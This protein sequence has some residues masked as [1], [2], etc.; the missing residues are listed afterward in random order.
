MLLLVGSANRDETVFP[1]PDRYDLDRDTSRLVSFGSG[2]HFCMGAPMARMEARIGPRRTGQAGRHLRHRPRRDRAGPLDQ[3]A[4]PGR[5]PDHGGPPLM[6]RFE[7]N[8]E[9]RPGGGHRSLVGHREGDGQGAGRHSATRWPSGPDGWPSARRPRRRSGPTVAKRWPSTSTWPT[10]T[11]WSS[12]PRRP[13]TPSEGRDPG[14]QRGPEHGRLGARHRSR[15]V[16]GGAPGQRQRHP[17]AGPRHGAGHGGP[18]R[19]G[20]IVFVT[21]DVVERPR[22]AM[23]AYVTSKWGLE[24]YVRSLQMELEG[25]GVRATIVRPGPTLT[26]MGMDWDPAVTAEV[27]EQWADV[28]IRPPLQLHA[29]GRGGQGHRRR[30]QSPPGHPRHRRRAPAGSTDHDRDRRTR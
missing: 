7:P 6:P 23:A 25:T 24:G 9:R 11:R 18:R 5:P 10:A 16:R 15:G 8:P 21:S 14:V 17:P 2:R 28:G 1:D 4:R 22:P 26:G 20:D 12:S 27:I 19:R 29:P 13:S 30:R 3:C